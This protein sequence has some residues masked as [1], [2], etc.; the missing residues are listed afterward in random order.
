MLGSTATV[1]QLL[2]EHRELTTRFGRVSPGQSGEG[3]GDKAVR[4]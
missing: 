3:V 2:K 1:L 4:L